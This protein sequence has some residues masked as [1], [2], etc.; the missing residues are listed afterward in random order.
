MVY[1]IFGNQTSTIKARSKKIAKETLGDVDEM[2][3]VRFD[4][5]NVLIQEAIDECNYIPLGYDKKVVI[6]ESCYFF[7]KPKPRN[8]IESEQDYDKLLEYLEHPNED[9]DLI[10]T[11]ISSKVES[12]SNFY[13][14]IQ[15]NGKII[16]VA[17][18]DATQWSDYV[19]SYC[20][21]KLGMD[22]DSMALSELSARTEGDVALFQNNAKKLALYSKHITYDDVC[23]MVSRPLEENAFQI[24]NYLVQEKNDKALVIYRDLKITNTEP[25]TLI[26]MLANQFRLLNQIAFLSKNHFS[27]DQ[28]ANELNIKPARVG[29]VKRSASM[30]SEK[31]IQRALDDL[32]NL[33][34]QIKS[35]L[36]DRFYAFE[37]FL[38][39]FKRR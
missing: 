27:N 18:P 23:L 17:D 7:L 5:E 32:F 29:A 20:R 19:S 22:I 37:L 21:D 14:A 6:V 1:F 33:D 16:Q 31:A 4:G 24:F 34:L 2:N 13:K 35:G 26:A 25:I 39:N 28:I 15:T 9:C 12:N 3:F 38:I 10:M 36:V 11:V 8:K 30:V